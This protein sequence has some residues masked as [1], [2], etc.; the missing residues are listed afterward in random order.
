MIMIN[1]NDSDSDDDDDDD[2]LTFLTEGEG[3]IAVSVII[4]G[5]FIYIF[6]PFRNL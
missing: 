1:N 4:G 3:L 6:L 5:S 2:K